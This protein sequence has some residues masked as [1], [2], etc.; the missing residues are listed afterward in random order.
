MQAI[1][2]YLFVSWMNR[3]YTSSIHEIWLICWA[4]LDFKV[5]CWNW[6]VR[7]NWSDYYKDFQEA[8]C[9]LGSRLIMIMSK[10]WYFLF[11][12]KWIIKV[13]CCLWRDDI[14]YICIKKFPVNFSLRKNIS[15]IF[16]KISIESK[17]IIRRNCLEL[18]KIDDSLKKIT[19]TFLIWIKTN[20]H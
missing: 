12:K 16:F 13:R 14:E 6:V 9:I 1:V 10:H 17:N 19:D 5:V 11:M 4:Y 20:L 8:Y 7:S 15:W 18:W 3:M 2:Q